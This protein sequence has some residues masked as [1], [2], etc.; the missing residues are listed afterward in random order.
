MLNIFFIGCFFKVLLFECGVVDYDLICTRERERDVAGT[1]LD[2]E[3][4]L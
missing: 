4:D 1:G 2:L 3:R